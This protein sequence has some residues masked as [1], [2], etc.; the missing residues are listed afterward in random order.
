MAAQ[1]KIP[2]MTSLIPN[3]DDSAR[4]GLSIDWAAAL[5]VHQVW[6]RSVV[7][8][9]V[10][11]RQATDD[12]LQEVAVA[13]VEQ[14]SPIAD[15]SKVA[16]WLYRL[17]V[18]HSMRYRRQRSRQRRHEDR[19]ATNGQTS[20]RCSDDQPADE[21][22]LSQERHDLVRSALGHLRPRE[23]EI[24]RLKYFENWTYQ[25]MAERM[26]ISEKALDARLH[27]ARL[28]LRAEL[29]RLLNVENDG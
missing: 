21:W 27:R 29:A 18:V 25:Q 16:P 5:V 4:T 12:V 7:G 23:S 14:R 9:L 3:F 24:L 19:A 20:R 15:P 26:G 1:S 22:L 11:E 10:G 17:A 2:V 13:A 6:L 8:A 28:R